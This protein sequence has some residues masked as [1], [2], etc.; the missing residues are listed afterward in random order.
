MA[1][2]DDLTV[3]DLLRGHDPAVVTAALWLRDLVI[4][5]VPDARE[6]VWPGWH[7]FGYRHP[8]AGYLCGVF[9]RERTVSLFFE[10][11]ARLPDPACLLTVSGRRGRSVVVERAGELPTDQIIALIDAAIDHRGSR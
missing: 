3:E 6:K 11:G 9:P 10:H 2:Q 7:G 4:S 5:T 1:Q 8:R